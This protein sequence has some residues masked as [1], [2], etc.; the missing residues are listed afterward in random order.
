MQDRLK[1][2]PTRFDNVK[3]D[4]QEYLQGQFF[5]VSKDVKTIK[6]KFIIVSLHYIF[7]AH[8]S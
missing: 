1:T 3:I 6:N 5:L 7:S 2:L 8:L 4:V